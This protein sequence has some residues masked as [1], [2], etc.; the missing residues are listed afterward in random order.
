MKE[1]RRMCHNCRAFSELRRPSK[2]APTA[3]IISA[4]IISCRLSNLSI[5]TPA[6]TPKSKLGKA[7]IA[8]TSPKETEELVISSTNHPKPTNIM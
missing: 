5:T 1:I 6:R 8:Q 7:P 2:K 3:L 4:Q